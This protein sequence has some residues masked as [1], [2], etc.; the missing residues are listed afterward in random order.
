[1]MIFFFVKKTL[2]RKLLEVELKKISGKISGK[3]LDIGSKDARYTEWFTGTVTSVDVIPNPQKKVLKGDIYNLN[4][5]LNSFDGVLSTE[6]FQYL[7]DPKKAVSEIYR[8]LK[9]DG[10]LILSCPLVYR[11]HED[12]VRYTKDFWEQLLKDFE[13]LKFCYIGNFYTVIL[14]IIREKITKLPFRLVRYLLYLFLM[15]LMFFVPLSLRLSK[16]RNF[17]S[18]YLILAKK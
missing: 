10:V 18:G 6:V 9:K 16:D 11:V 4:F 3:I 12:L 5:P 15:V 2:H 17:V 8:V 13:S 7:E 14:D 1:M